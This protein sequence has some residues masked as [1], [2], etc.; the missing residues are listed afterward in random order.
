MNLFKFEDKLKN[1]YSANSLC[2]IKCFSNHCMVI[3]NH[4][5][6][7]SAWDEST[8]VELIR[9]YIEDYWGT[10]DVDDNTPQFVIFIN[11]KYEEKVNQGLL[12]RWFGKR[13]DIKNS[14]LDRLVKIPESFCRICSFM[15]I[16]EL[17]PI[18]RRHLENWF[19]EHKIAQ[20]ITPQR[21]LEYT[22]E[23]FPEGCA[24]RADGFCRR[25][26]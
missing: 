22:N 26:A 11:I 5:I 6:D 17:T 13:K 2:S 24:T 21:R 1:D 3:F 23:L 16:D 14:I 4:N 25:K 19:D 9:W 20:E 10:L 12:S 15:V 7:A 8:D 18:E